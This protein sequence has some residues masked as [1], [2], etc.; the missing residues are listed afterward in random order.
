MH[1]AL[2][3]YACQSMDYSLNR[4]QYWVKERPFS[5]EHVGY[6]NADRFC[7]RN[8]NCDEEKDLKPTVYCHK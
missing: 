8:N 3:F 2:F 1:L 7:D 5:F 6:E 4:S